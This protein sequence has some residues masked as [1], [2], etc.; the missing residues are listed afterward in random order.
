MPLKLDDRYLKG[1]ISQH[2]YDQLEPQ[3]K[4]ANSLLM[5]GEGAGNDF[6]GWVTLPEDYD[7]EEFENE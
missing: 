4:A 1:F 2:E 3:V 6:L 7:K 5:S